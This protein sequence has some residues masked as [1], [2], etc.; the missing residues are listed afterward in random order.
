MKPILHRLNRLI[1]KN[2]VLGMMA[3]SFWVVPLSVTLIPQTALAEKKECRC[4]RVSCGPCQ[5]RV[6]VGK[7]VRFCDWGD[8]NVC[9]KYVCEN[10][11]A[12]FACLSKQ[13]KP[14]SKKKRAIEEGEGDL[15][16]AYEDGEKPAVKKKKRLPA[17]KVIG[18]RRDEK[19]K[20]KTDG[21]VEVGNDTRIITGV[22]Y[23]DVISGS[24]SQFSKGLK[25]FHR[26]QFVPMVKNQKLFVGDEIL[27]KSDK[28]KKL[29]LSYA[30]G[31]VALAL[32]AKSKIVIQ[33]PHSILGYFQPFLYLV[34]GGVE[35][36]VSFKQGSFDL[37]AGQ[38]LT[39]SKGGKHRVFYEMAE[40]G[41][42]VT[43]KSLAD[44]LDVIRSQ[45]LS[46]KTIPVK[47]G[48]FMSWVSETPRQLFSMDEK[49]ALAGEGF[50]T[51]VFQMPMEQM[52][53]MGLLKKP[54]KALF[55][56]WNKD[57]PS[58]A[59]RSVA[60]VNGH[61]LCKAPSAGFQQCAW[62]CEGN[63]KKA[64]SCDAQ[65]KNVHCVRR[66][67]NAAGQWS[68][69]TVF[70]SSYSDLCPKQGVRVGECNP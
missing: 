8:I 18:S 2:L 44:S 50:I 49:Q 17:S 35:Y 52:K 69:P 67:C 45:D 30:N 62:S 59:R 10:V 65:K 61:E 24:V 54:K 5:R 42:K 47:A 12:Y 21:R 9:K 20:L 11:D 13:D 25:V 68:E 40:E 43:V 27:N 33:D 16:L 53:K 3:F 41:L 31:K 48:Q 4:P 14:A 57:K 58:K 15:E 60:S 63:G 22:E 7:I 66:M 70:A 32:Q 28:K 29:E 6:S 64:K 46:G 51:P 55:S 26:G 38:I 19:I 1:L 23:S 36:K 34:Y 37:L 56:D 39:R